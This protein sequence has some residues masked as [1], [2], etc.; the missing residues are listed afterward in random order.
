M[1][2][3][4]PGLAA[5]SSVSKIA[6]E[7]FEYVGELLASIDLEE[8]ERVVEILRDARERGAGVYIVGNGGSAA[9]ASHFACDLA[10]GAA[11]PGV[12]AMRVVSLTDNVPLLT[13]LANDYGYPDV[14]ERQLANLLQPGDAVIAISA[15]GNSPNLVR[16]VERA[17]RL[18]A[19][20]VAILAFDGG[21]LRDAVDVALFVPSELGHYGPAEDVHLMLQHVITSCLSQG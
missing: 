3:S 17:R 20:T 8:L 14:F 18:G 13:A 1:R 21:V 9:T 7:Y 6:T 10:K 19:T 5:A 15:S 16:A 4:V 12:P 11:G 2:P